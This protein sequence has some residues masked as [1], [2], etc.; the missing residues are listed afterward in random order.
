MPDPSQDALAGAIDY[1]RLYNYRFKDVDQA[2]RAAVWGVLGP[3]LWAQ[4]GR[5]QR[6]LDPA[7]G[8]FEFLNAIPAAERWAVDQVDTG[9]ARDPTIRLEFGDAQQ[10]ALPA[11]HFDGVFVSHFLEHLAS[12]QH[13]ALFLRKLLAATAPG[14]TIAVLGPNFR[15]C[16]SQYFD[17][18]DHIVPLSHVSVAEHLH[19]AGYEVGRIVPRFL[20][21]SFRSALPPSSRLT[22]AYLRLTPAWRLLGKQL[23]VLA[24]RP[25]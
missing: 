23:L 21:F 13:V 25:R 22:A 17:C 11:D 18:A 9:F 15:Y 16:A 6:V 19:A 20:P 12:Q 8:R 24:R 7:A 3:W 4:M 1:E 10:V 14:G 2:G 5:P